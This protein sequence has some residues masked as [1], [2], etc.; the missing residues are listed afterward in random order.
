M[1]EHYFKKPT[2][3]DQIRASWLAEP[4]EQYVHWLG[5]REYS[6]TSIY[7]RVP[8]IRR[9]GEFAWRRGERHLRQLPKLI[10]PFVKC[11][12][13]KHSCSKGASRTL[14]TYQRDIRHPIV[15]MLRVVGPVR[16]CKKPQQPFSKCVP[17]YFSYLK[18]ERGLSGPTIQLYQHHLSAFEKYLSRV[19]I[20]RFHSISPNT[21]DGFI[22]DRRQTLCPGSLHGVCA[23]LRSLFRYSFREGL[24]PVDLVD[25]IEGPRVYQLSDIPRCL[26]WKEVLRA[27]N[28]ID[29]RSAI[30]KRDYAMLLLLATYG[31][32]AR[33]VGSLRLDDIDWSSNT[34]HIRRRKAGNSTSYPLALE[35]GEA[36]VDYLKNARPKSIHRQVFLLDRAPRGPAGSRVVSSQA[37]THLD[38]AGITAPKLG[39]HTFRHSVAQRLVDSNFS[40]KV[41][42]DYLGHQSTASTRIYSKISVESL[43]ELVLNEGEGLP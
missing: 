29:R 10:E 1:L 7:K 22:A 6:A 13:R 39:S 38:A 40:L 42:G 16:D 9:F 25:V 32:R 35:V 19:R 34:L 43:R 21:L 36:I 4:I 5:E 11:E 31:L 12:S 3:I 37:K 15:Q 18:Q 33:E 17:G 23:A 24:T 14:R 41:V 28:G 27:I 30:G 8:L 20:K 26:P 2:T